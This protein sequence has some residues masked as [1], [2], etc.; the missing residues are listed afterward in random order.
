MPNFLSRYTR[1]LHTQW[2]AGVVEKLPRV[3]EDGATN[4][5]GLYVVGDLTGVPLLKFSADSGARAVQTICDDPSFERQRA[6]ADG[7]TLDLV[8]IGGGVSG[9]AAALEARKKGLDFRLLEAAEP[10][11][12]I[13]NFPKGKPIYTYPTEMTPAG[14]IQFSAEVKEPLLDELRQQT[15]AAGIEPVAARA[16]RVERKSGALEVVIPKGE[17]L[18]GHRVIVAIGRSG[19]FRKLGV[20]GEELDKVS[21][22]LHDPKDYAGKDVLVVGGG[23]SALET[24][25]AVAQCGARVTLSYRKPE[26]SRPKPDNIAKLDELRRDP[27]ADVGVET[28]TSERVS[29]SSGTFLGAHRQ[30]GSIELQLGTQVREIAADSVLLVDGEKKEHRVNNDAVF[31]MIGREAPLD[32]FRRSGVKIRGETRGLEW[33]TVLVFF[34]LIWWIYDWKNDGLLAS[35]LPALDQPTAFPSNVPSVLSSLGDGFRAQIEDRS[36]VLGTLAVSMKGRSFYYTLLYTLAIVVF[37]IQRIR[38]RRTPYV[39][40]QTL[41]LIAVQAIPLF[42]LPELILPW[43]GYNGW[44]DSGTGASIAN[45]F[46]ELY[47]SEQQYL[48]QQWPD[49]GHPR[50]YWRAYGLILAW[51]L[52]VYNAFT[53]QPL[54]GWLI[55][56]F[57]QT[58]VLIPLLIWR[59]GK[60]AYCGW[61]CSCGGLAETMGDTLRYKM[62]HG[63]FWN[64]LNMVGQVILGLAFVL[65]GWRILGWLNPD[66]FFDQSFYTLLEGS[67]DG[68]GALVNPLSWKW[69]V[70]VL[71][72]G[73]LGVGLYIKY[74]GRVWCR[75]ACPLAA[76]M[77]IYSRFSQFGILAEKK[78]CISCNVCTSVCH[79]GIDIMNFANKGLP[80]RDPQCVRCSACVQSCP[81]GVLEFGRV[82]AQGAELGRDRLVAS[83]V[84]A[85]EGNP[86][87]DEMKVAQLRGGTE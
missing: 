62:P 26:F 45:E 68:D 19:N 10:F 30:P 5:P 64:R 77:N 4:V 54:L 31:S 47:I 53:D 44:F 3:R 36:T 69:G 60:G 66:G 22:R 65:L 87:P 8:I 38:R 21:N 73:I 79:M 32:F 78:K 82:D 61:I 80:M 56:G 40:W 51:P 2:P 9:F 13:A 41:S 72:G 14:D 1:W 12:T 86:S 29:A 48:A 16:E 74:S 33:V 50:A 70:D 37:G 46:F 23:D 25:I 81:T 35:R 71:L 84:T 43:M 67:R 39:R 34:L 75:F 58:F 57:V 6:A 49:W 76:L 7:A 59:W 42:L 18:R 85:R 55:L 27:S 20:A 24:A 15:L 83:P 17:S 52:S 28:P 11:S 63:A